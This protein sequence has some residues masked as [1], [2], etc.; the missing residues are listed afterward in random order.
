MSRVLVIGGSRGIGNNIIKEQLSL[1]R[2][3][4]SVSR[5][6]S[7]IHDNN[8]QEFNVDVISGDLPD[9]DNINALVYCPGSIILK[10]FSQITEDDYKNDF[11][12]NV[13][14]AVRCI[15][16]YISIIKSHDNA[17]MVLF[18]TVAVNQGMPFHSSVSV[19]K[20]GVEGLSKTLAA[21]FAPK[22]RVNCIAPTLTK[23]DL[24]SRILR[25]EKIEENIANKHPLKRICE[26]E[27]ISSMATFLLS[28][29]AR[30][31]SGQILRVDA[32]MSTLKI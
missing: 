19:A 30:S 14:G 22:V 21:E 12:I 16:K 27:D 24:A 15:K 3:C 10:P 26:S 31:I 2:E 9:I 23:T 18:S 13:L 32:G 20:A 8:L 4:V 6:S 17:S 1:G 11:E 7:G 28:E 25:N 29:K 5:N